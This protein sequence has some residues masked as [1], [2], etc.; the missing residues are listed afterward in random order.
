MC[1]CVCVCEGGGLSYF[2]NG[3]AYVL[4]WGLKFEVGEIIWGLKIDKRNSNEF[5][6]G[7][8]I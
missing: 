8:M 2:W 3:G 4:I 6:S 7:I 5:H 1:V